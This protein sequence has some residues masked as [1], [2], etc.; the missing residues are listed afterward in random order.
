MTR[1]GDT[2][3]PTCAHYREPARPG[4]A[5]TCAKRT[6]PHGPPARVAAVLAWEACLGKHREARR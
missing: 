6:H 3:C 4:A 2:Q 5:P 1:I